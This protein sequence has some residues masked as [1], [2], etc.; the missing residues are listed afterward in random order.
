MLA[1]IVTGRETVGAVLNKP[2]PMGLVGR[3]DIFFLRLLPG[4]LA[5]GIV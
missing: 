2:T 1:D 3:G 4:S 5:G